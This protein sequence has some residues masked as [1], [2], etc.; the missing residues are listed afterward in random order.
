MR[1]SP[2]ALFACVSLWSLSPACDSPAPQNPDEDHD[3]SG[4]SA[5]DQETYYVVTRSD[6]R[7]C[8]APACGGFFVK[9]VNQ[10]TTTCADGKPQAEC[11]VGTIDLSALK[12]EGGDETG[13][14]EEFAQKHALVRGE[15]KPD[16]DPNFAAVG[17][18][19]ASEGWRG[20]AGKEAGGT[21]YRL[22]GIHAK[23]SGLPCPSAHAFRL[24]T[25]WDALIA[26]VDLAASG[27]PQEA[28]D[29]ANQAMYET[30]E[31]ILVTAE[32]TTVS[33]P[34]GTMKGLVASEFYTRAAPAA[35]PASGPEC[36]GIR[37]VACGEGQ[38]CDP[39]QCGGADIGGTC[40]TRSEACTMDYR[41]VC[42]CDG[43]T[44]G[45]D[46]ARLG[47]GVGRAHEGECEKAGP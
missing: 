26:S 12:L 10:E 21:F 27:A 9:R 39:S 34:N 38:F 47:A 30:P 2:F 1:N 11:Y 8:A 22:R 40:V 43:K 32:P 14:L 19:V 7:K 24:N 28:Q 6:V 29:V 3:N 16:G 42:G 15:L 36:G 37:G 13:L 41:P 44:Y 17:R 46:C 4:A 5:A 45:N 35:A 23:C 33:G 25:G 31:G 20:R 18:L